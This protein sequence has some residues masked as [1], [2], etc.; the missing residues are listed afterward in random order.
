M[1]DVFIHYYNYTVI[2]KLTLC[3]WCFGIPG[4]LRIIRA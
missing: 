4:V 2:C 1:G 3:L